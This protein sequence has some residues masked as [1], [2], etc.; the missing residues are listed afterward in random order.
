MFIIER[1]SGV[2]PSINPSI[3]HSV[4][5]KDSSVELDVLEIDRCIR[6]IDT[7]AS[8]EGFLEVFSTFKRVAN[9]LKDE[10]LENEFMVNQSLL[11][12]EAEQSLYAKATAVIETNFD[13]LEERLDALFALKGP[14]DT[15]FDNVMVN[16]EDTDIRANRKALVGMI[17]KEIYTVADIKNITL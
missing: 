4:V 15:F 1:L 11:N 14:I 9:I 12:E 5:S 10:A 6:A 17:Y 13:T 2:Y 16:H 3:I 7:I 8:S